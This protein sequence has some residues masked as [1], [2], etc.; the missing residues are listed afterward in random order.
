MLCFYCLVSDITVARPLVDTISTIETS[1]VW[2]DLRV[3]ARNI[4]LHADYY[5]ERPADMGDVLVIFQFQMDVTQQCSWFLQACGSGH[6]HWG[7][8]QPLR[9]AAG[10]GAGEEGGEGG[11]QDPPTG[12]GRAGTSPSGRC[13]HPPAGGTL[14][15]RPS[16]GH[17][18]RP[19]G[20]RSASMITQDL[21]I[22]NL[23]PIIENEM[24]EKIG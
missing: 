18:H 10:A 2:T 3:I 11:G 16:P 13:R 19:P 6:H 8:L 17:H 12:W 15:G 20:H 22:W 14:P 1:L 7:S 21:N 24:C 4:F 23:F 9:G 5:I